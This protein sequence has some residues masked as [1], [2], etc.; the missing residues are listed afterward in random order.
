L[1]ARKSQASVQSKQPALA[2][3]GAAA[4]SGFQP[5]RSLAKRFSLSDE[6][7]PGSSTEV[8]V[9]EVPPSPTKRPKLVKD[10]DRLSKGSER[11]PRTTRKSRNDTA[12]LGSR[13][14]ASKSS[15]PP[16]L[17][18]ASENQ[19]LDDPETE[20][21]IHV[22]LTPEN[23]DKIAQMYKK[24][25]LENP[26]RAIRAAIR[27]AKKRIKLKVKPQTNSLAD[28]SRRREP[29]GMVHHIVKAANLGEKPN[30][31]TE[32]EEITES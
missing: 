10:D 14:V 6:I 32:D 3:T 1:P 23:W 5:P 17:P 8:D 9:Y 12:L 25:E 15:E 31:A 4:A 24:F 2:K 22:K 26:D 13:R 18:H 28:D 30:K 7:D 11:V 20:P 21:V 19:S 16:K 27:A 29:R